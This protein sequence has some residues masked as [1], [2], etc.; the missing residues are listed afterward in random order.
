M[1]ISNCI[2]A[3]PGWTKQNSEHYY[4]ENMDF[5]FKI[6][7]FDKATFCLVSVQTFDV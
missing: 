7:Q 3:N 6:Q 4:D 5:K 1:F 2:F